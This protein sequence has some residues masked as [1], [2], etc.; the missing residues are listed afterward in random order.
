MVLKPIETGCLAMI[1]KSRAGNE[2]KVVT[3]GNF[4]GEVPWYHGKNRWE[5][6]QLVKATNDRGDMKSCN[7]V[8]ED[9]MMRI[10]GEDFSHEVFEEELEKTK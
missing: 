1:I 2:G 6:D 5:I 3:V 9:Y 10:D 7:H 8:R 4:I